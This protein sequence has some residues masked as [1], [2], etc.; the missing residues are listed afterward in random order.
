MK[1]AFRTKGRRLIG[2]ESVGLALSGGGYRAAAFH[3]GVLKRLDE[4]SIL[5]R[6][7]L[8]SCVSG[9]SI[10]GALYALRCSQTGEGQPGSYSVDEF[11]GEFKSLLSRNLRGWAYAGTP[12]RSARALLGFLPRLRHAPLLVEEVN[13]ELF[14]DARLSDLPEWILINATNLQTGKNWKFFRDAAGD[15]LVGATTCTDQIHLAT[16]VVASAAHPLLVDPVPLHADWTDYQASNLDERWERPPSDSPDDES[17]WRIRHGS[18]SGHTTFHLADGGV[19]DNEGVNGLR[20]AGVEHAILSSA[21]LTEGPFKRWQGIGARLRTIAVMHRRLGAINRQFVYE[22]THSV[23]P[24][25]ARHQLLAIAG[26]VAETSDDRAGN[27]SL[28]NQ[29]KELAGVGWPPRG[30]QFSSCAMILLHKDDVANNRSAEYRERPYDIPEDDRG[31]PPHLVNE[32]ARVRADVDAH[33]PEL[34]DMLIAQ[35]YFLADAHLK[36]GTPEVVKACTG[37]GDRSAEALRPGW[38]WAHQVI[39]R[40]RRRPN[41]AESIISSSQ[42]RR[43]GFGRTE[44][45]LSL[46]RFWGSVLSVGIV[47]LALIGLTIEWVYGRLF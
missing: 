33:D 29:L 21:T 14:R 12:L 30:R 24:S 5:P 18:Q 22:A 8:V 36:I 11:I 42:G 47:L 37:V 32:L 7:D 27:R 31:L 13:R 10:I 9:G 25:E 2:N 39:E 4:M 6:I 43:F 34:V 45:A 44:N 20:G 41:V 35:G 40:A 3:L 26:R 19:Y 38:N 16:A 17:A 23:D 46:G 28:D 15:Y 1:T